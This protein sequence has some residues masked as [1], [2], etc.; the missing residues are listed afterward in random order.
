LTSP[1][2]DYSILGILSF[3]IVK[4]IKGSE[5]LWAGKELLWSLTTA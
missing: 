2:N 4:V 1:G 5:K 3:Y